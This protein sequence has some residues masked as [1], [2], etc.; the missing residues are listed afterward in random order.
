MFTTQEKEDTLKVYEE[1]KSMKEVIQRLGYPTRQT[2]YQWLRE[3]NNSGKKVK[4]PRKRINNSFDHPLHPSPELK[5]IR[6]IQMEIDILNEEV[7]ILK[8]PRRNKYSLPQLSG[9]VRLSKSNY[10]YVKSSKFDN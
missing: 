1:V 9:K 4:P 5:L 3:K 8:K 7:K 6:A 2:F 10:Y